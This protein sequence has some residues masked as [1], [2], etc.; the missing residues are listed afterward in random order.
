MY[1]AVDMSETK[2]FTRQLTALAVALAICELAWGQEAQGGLT[3]RRIYE[4]FKSGV[5]TVEILRIIATAP[6]IEFDLRPGATFALM[7]AGVSAEIIKAM[8]AREKGAPLERETARADSSAAGTAASRFA[9][10][11][12]NSDQGTYYRSHGEWAAMEPEIVHWKGMGLKTYAT[13]GLFKSEMTGRILS[14]AS[15]LRLTLP[16]QFLVYCP[17]GADIT[18]YRLVRLR[19]RANSREFSIGNSGRSYDAADLS[20]RNASLRDQRIATPAWTIQID[21]GPGEYGLLPPSEPANGGGAANKV[22]TFTV[23]E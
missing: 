3:D 6:E 17:E 7:K 21:V 23:V 9:P 11:P 5:Q 12:A 19:S 13:A 18:E 1:T 2:G 22:Y 4:L 8:A 10:W 14:S 16:I 15:R 20:L